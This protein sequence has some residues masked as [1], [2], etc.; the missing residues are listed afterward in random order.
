[1]LLTFEQRFRSPFDQIDHLNAGYQHLAVQISGSLAIGSKRDLTTHGP[2]AGSAWALIAPSESFN[3]LE[4]SQC[5]EQL[6]AELDERLVAID[7]LATISESSADEMLETVDAATGLVLEIDSSTYGSY[8][9]ES[10]L[11]AVLRTLSNIREECSSVD[12]DGIG[13]ATVELLVFESEEAIARVRDSA[14][15]NTLELEIQQSRVPTDSGNGGN[16]VVAGVTA[17]AALLGSLAGVLVG[18]K[19]VIELVEKRRQPE[20]AALHLPDPAD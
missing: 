14:A 13:Q 2:N 8:A 11:T 12:L 15:A 7:E 1:M 3:D 18:A 9:D 16:N 4:T 19:G 17:A 20:Q 5:R 10:S 6:L